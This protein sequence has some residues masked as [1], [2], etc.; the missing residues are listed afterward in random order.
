MIRRVPLLV[1]LLCATACA[2]Q[3]PPTGLSALHKAETW[4]QA[5]KVYFHATKSPARPDKWDGIRAEAIDVRLYKRPRPD[6]VIATYGETW[7][8]TTGWDVHV[9]LMGTNDIPVYPGNLYI[10]PNGSY[11]AVEWVNDNTLAIY[12]PSGYYP[13]ERDYR[14]GRSSKSPTFEYEKGT[15]N[16]KFIAADRSTMVAKEEAMNAKAIKL[17][18]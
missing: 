2:P 15:I 6:L 12:Y 4:N 7:F 10:C 14:T 16:V 1:L 5:R 9:A 8:N 3:Q 17:T 13:D 18:N 11:F